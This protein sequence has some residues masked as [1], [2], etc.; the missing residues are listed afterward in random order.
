MLSRVGQSVRS[1]QPARQSHKDLLSARTVALGSLHHMAAKWQGSAWAKTVTPQEAATALFRERYG[2]AALAEAVTVFA[3]G[4]V[5]LIGEHTDYNE[6]FVMPFCIGRY[7]VI[8]AR[9]TDSPSLIASLPGSTWRPRK[10]A[11]RWPLTSSRARLP[12][13]TLIVFAAKPIHWTLRV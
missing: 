2:E 7:T 12:L 6:G 11:M 8:A 9:R 5:N 1:R 10:S 4:R 13:M 3:P